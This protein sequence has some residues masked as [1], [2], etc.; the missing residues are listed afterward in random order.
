MKTAG[1][2]SPAL[3]ALLVVAVAGG[4]YLERDKLFGGGGK[5]G[6]EEPKIVFDAKF[7]PL[8]RLP[9]PGAAKP[10]AG[11]RAEARRS[12]FD[13]GLSPEALAAE[14]ARKEAEAR[15][16]ERRR[17]EEE[18][19]KKEAEALAKLPPPPP[20][21]PPPPAAPS[22]NYN[23]V[24]YIARL[25]DGGFLGV[26]QRRGG[27]NQ[28]TRVVAAG[29]TIDNAFVVKKIDVGAL[30]VGFADPQFKDRVE[31]VRLAAEPA[32]R[33]PRR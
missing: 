32:G 20:P 22:F 23:Y 29:E 6:G 19:R 2:P 13:Y 26:I 16:A 1:R 10:P 4:V 17:K 21:P 31:T 30:T 12:L 24:G 5:A 33:G 11:A 28:P 27:P 14:R 25:A 18:R 3:L 9:A 7:A 8:L 15:E